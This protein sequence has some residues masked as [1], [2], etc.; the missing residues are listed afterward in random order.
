MK[1]S[2]FH[3][4]RWRRSRLLV[5]AGERERRKAMMRVALIVHELLGANEMIVECGANRP[6]TSRIAHLVQL[7][8]HQVA[9]YCVGERAGLKY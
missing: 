5:A 1:R 2:V 8:V 3:W 7:L 9:L 4:W 6:H